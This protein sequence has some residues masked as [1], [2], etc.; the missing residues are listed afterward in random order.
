MQ[1]FRL[2]PVLIAGLMATSA[3]GADLSAKKLAEAVAVTPVLL[4]AVSGVNG[5]IDLAGGVTTGKGLGT[6]G[7]GHVGG[8]L[9]VPLGAQYG[10]QVDALAAAMDELRM[11]GAG[12]HAFWRDPN[13][14]LIGVY[15]EGLGADVGT[16][17]LKKA[18]VGAEGELYFGRATLS[19]L[20]GYEWGNL[21]I[22]DGF[23]AEALAGFYA[24]DDVKLSAGYSYGF[25]GHMGTARVDWQL[26]NGFAGNATSLYGEAWFGEGGYAA[27]LVGVKMQF[28]VAAKSLKRHEREDD[29]PMWIKSQP[30][31]IAAAKAQGQFDKPVNACTSLLSTY[32]SM[33]AQWIGEGPDLYPDLEFSD[34]EDAYDAANT[35]GCNPEELK[36]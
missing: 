15:G 22:R 35:A 13:T 24:T 34:I 20:A 2:L 23:F 25:A 8:S 1:A 29:P 4:P 30:H 18:R 26:P 31:A 11:I 16:D 10:V 3:H 27:G 32:N 12:G 19:G 5:S 6:G 28:G 17:T 9:S 7:Y 36:G 14:A 33:L 21:D